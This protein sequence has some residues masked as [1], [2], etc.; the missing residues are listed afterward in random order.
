MSAAEVVKDS[1]D[2]MAGFS[3]GVWASE[4]LDALKAAGYAVVELPGP[5]TQKS[6]TD[7]ENGSQ[8]WDYPHGSVT[9]FDDGTIEWG[10]FHHSHPWKL[11]AA[12]AALLAAADAA[13]AQR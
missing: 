4:A 10:Q 1:L 13:E 5:S 8:S 11:T 12:A 6:A 9:V 2:R 3:T 7:D